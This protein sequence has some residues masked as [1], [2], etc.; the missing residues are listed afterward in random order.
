MTLIGKLCDVLKGGVSE[1]L[2]CARNYLLENLVSYFPL[3]VKVH[4]VNAVLCERILELQLWPK[5]LMLRPEVLADTSKPAYE[6]RAITNECLV[7]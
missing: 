4:G 3:I 5:S 1:R 2:V 6:L 7:L